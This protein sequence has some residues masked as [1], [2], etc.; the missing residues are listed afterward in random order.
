[1]RCVLKDSF[2]NTLPTDRK[3]TENVF[4]FSVFFIDNY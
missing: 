2:E 3:R 4:T 1:M